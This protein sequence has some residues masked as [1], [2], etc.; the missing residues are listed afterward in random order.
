M[1]QAGSHGFFPLSG[2]KIFSEELQLLPVS[3]VVRGCHVGTRMLLIE[4]S[5]L[6]FFS[7][8]TEAI[9]F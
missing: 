6:G 5:F 3:E 8:R 9:L 1:S 4:H 2:T 7:D